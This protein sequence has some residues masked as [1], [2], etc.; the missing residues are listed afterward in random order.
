MQSLL[1]APSTLDN[2][3]FEQR[4]DHLALDKLADL[5]Y[6]EHTCSGVQEAKPSDD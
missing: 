3:R 1:C 4:Q 5:E 2:A 6:A